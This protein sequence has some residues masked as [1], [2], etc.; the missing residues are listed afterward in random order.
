MIPILRIVVI[1]SFVSFILFLLWITVDY[2]GPPTAG[3]CTLLLIS[4][5]VVQSLACEHSD[6]AYYEC[7]KWSHNGLL[8]VEN[9]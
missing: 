7:F 1:V 9:T 5:L 6:E 8:V 2:S 4:D 3:Y